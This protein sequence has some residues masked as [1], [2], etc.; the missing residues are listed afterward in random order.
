VV[1]DKVKTVKELLTEHF[2]KWQSD[3]GEVKRQT[4]FAAFIGESEKYLSLVMSGTRA[5]SKRQ[6]EHFADFFKDPRFYDAVGLERPDPL[7][8]YTRRNWGSVP[9]ELKQRIAD[10]IAQYTSEPLPNGG[11]TETAK[12]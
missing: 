12:P 9:D 1:T 6:V 11:E 7:L 4:E 8:A 5:P 2:L 10:E 3:S